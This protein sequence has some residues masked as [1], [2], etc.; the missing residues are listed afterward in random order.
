MRGYA[1]QSVNEA[2]SDPW[3][4]SYADFQYGY[5]LTILM[6]VMALLPLFG[7][8]LVLMGAGKLRSAQIDEANLHLNMV[9]SATFAASPA[10]R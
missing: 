4:I 7:L 2:C 3:G 9:R 6:A 5:V 10:F 8:D 1:I